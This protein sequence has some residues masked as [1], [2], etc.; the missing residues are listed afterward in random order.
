MK[1]FF[2]VAIASLFSLSCASAQT[3]PAPG[4]LAPTQSRLG[5]NLSGPADWNT[6]LPFN[7]LFHFARAWIS[8]KEGAGWNQGPPLQLDENGNIKS[9]EA[10]CFAETPLLT[11]M[12]G[13]YPKGRY[14][15]LYDGKGEVSVQGAKEISKAPNRIVFEPNG[16]DGVFVRLK[17][18][19]PNNYVKNIRVLLPG[20]ENS[21]KTQPFNPVFLNRWKS[22]NTLR[23]M[24]WMQ[25]NNSSVATWNDRPKVSDAIWTTKGVPLEIMIALCNRQNQNGWFCIPAHAD[26][27]YVRH[28]AQTLKTGLK[29]DLKAYIEYSNEV[30]N[31]QFEQNHYA[32]EQGLKAGIGEK[33]W[34]AGWHFTARRSK[35][36]FAIFDAVYGGRE[37]AAKRIV[38]V[39]STQVVNTYV[40]E[41]ILDF[42]DAGKSADVLAVAP[43][44][45]MVAVPRSTDQSTKIPAEDVQN[46]TQDQALDYL[47][48]VAIPETQ[49]WTKEQKAVADKYGLKLVAYEGGQHAVGALGAEGNDKITGL[50]T[51][52]N[53]SPRMG[54]LY[55]RY[56]DGWNRNGGDL[57]CNF[58]S[59][60]TWSKWGSWGLLESQDDDTPKY[61]AVL[62]WNQANALKK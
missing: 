48:Q 44:F 38:R 7:D 2:S 31:S 47:E 25:T 34:D 22:F 35:Q 60:G 41:Q 5:M 45:G 27:D 46:M 30:W 50:F 61:R 59:V 43:Y 14:V 56:L 20:T 16:H 9:L 21:Y 1:L 33:P 52:I 3:V 10:G 40:S 57:F 23:F 26:D 28:F 53:R 24:D 4:A 29:P 19:D 12:N 58:S 18:V 51:S 62:A 8:Q 36:I 55:T 17:S 49:R 32:S 6:E 15:V 42:E 37:A 11:D 54:A 39:I 13:H